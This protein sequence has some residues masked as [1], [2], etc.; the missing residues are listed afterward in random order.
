MQTEYC[1]C[2][3][4][5]G[6]ILALWRIVLQE[7]SCMLSYKGGES[8]AKKTVRPENQNNELKMD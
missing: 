3:V 4:V 1:V 6:G 5:L 2:S 8:D 7:K